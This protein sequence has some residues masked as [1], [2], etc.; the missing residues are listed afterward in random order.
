MNNSKETAQLNLD[1]QFVSK[2]NKTLLNLD[3]LG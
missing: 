2:L 1:V 3:V